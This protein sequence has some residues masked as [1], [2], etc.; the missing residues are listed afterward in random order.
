[1]LAA[2]ELQ[3]L[4]TRKTTVQILRI[5]TAPQA[6]NA[7]C[8]INEIGRMDYQNQAFLLDIMEEGGFSVNKYGLH[9][10]IESP[11]T[12]IATSNPLNSEWNDHYKISHSEMP[13]LKPLLDKFDQISAF[14]DFA[15]MEE[16]RM[17]ARKKVE[18][19]KKNIHY[20]CN[21]LRKYLLFMQRLSIQ[22]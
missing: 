1:M 9:I 7:I 17:Y 4:L 20:N 3:P 5:S 6:R 13:I 10:Q 8:A 15:S 22:F 21:Y 14:N 12:I 11:T 16:S 19:S 2:R 18:L